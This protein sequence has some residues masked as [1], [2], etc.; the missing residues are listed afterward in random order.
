MDALVT[1]DLTTGPD[2]QRFSYDERVDEILIRY[3]PDDP[4]H[5]TWVRARPFLALCVERTMRR[6]AEADQPI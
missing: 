4:V 5:R 1:A 3:P 2:G 6:L